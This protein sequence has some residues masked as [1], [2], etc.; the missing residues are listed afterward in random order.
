MSATGEQIFSKVIFQRSACGS[1][2]PPPL[3]STHLSTKTVDKAAA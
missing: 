3:P 1:D 2:V